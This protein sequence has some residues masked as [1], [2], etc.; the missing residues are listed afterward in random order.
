MSDLASSLSLEDP[1]TRLR[2]IKDALNSGD[3]QA[4]DTL[5]EGLERE[6]NPRVRRAMI[7][8]IGQLGGKAYAKTLATMT[9]DPDPGVRLQAADSL[10]RLGDAA[11]PPLVRLLGGD[12]EQKI[13]DFAAHHLIKLGQDSLFSLF[14]RML[15]S[16]RSWQREAV[17][18]ACKRFN[19]P[20]MV[21]FLKA[22]VLKETD[23]IRDEAYSGLQKLAEHGH[24]TA[25]EA[26]EE[27]QGQSP[28][29]PSPLP[30]I[31][32]PRM[33]EE[34]RLHFDDTY[35]GGP[36]VRVPMDEDPFS[37][38]D[39]GRF[40]VCTPDLAPLPSR[41]APQ[42][43]TIPL[44]M[45]MPEETSPQGLDPLDSPSEP[46]VTP[47]GP[48]S[49]EGYVHV[50]IG[51]GSRSGRGGS[52][53]SR[54]KSS[55]GG[56]RQ[57]G[58][59]PS[60]EPPDADGDSPVDGPMETS[61]IP[62]IPG[63][64]GKPQDL[65]D[66]TGIPLV[67]A[68]KMSTRPCPVC[69]EEIAVLAKKCRF[70]NEVFDREGLRSIRQYAPVTEIPT[71]LNVM[72]I[73]FLVLSSLG[74]FGYVFRATRF[75]LYGQGTDIMNGFFCLFWVLL[76]G[77][78]MWIVTAVRKR[79]SYALKI[80]TDLSYISIVLQLIHLDIIGMIGLGLTCILLWV[81]RTDATIRYCSE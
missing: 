38:V 72:S 29:K 71:G 63:A 19:T 65:E 2:A 47:R 39:S 16:E 60:F 52:S 32:V 74:F 56:V 9:K 37:R 22:A 30:S 81:L 70:C 68:A 77:A 46:L 11:Y 40:A 27:I 64:K 23:S 78:Q 67:S 36:V 34:D 21:P 3:K 51:G 6:S 75:F 55:L 79:S 35:I 41:V 18:L 76:I 50:E 5:V 10:V 45:A 14:R 12:P 26:I 61:R 20:L 57:R 49:S 66:G 42:K 4:A 43:A 31:E 25:R 44:D 7:L 54:A 1:V 80:W 15:E 58:A 48:G 59:P 28:S 33:P 73:I 8:A 13:R 17:V 53:P 62:G 24:R 69:G